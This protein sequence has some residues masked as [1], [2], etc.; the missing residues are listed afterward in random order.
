MSKVLEF[1]QFATLFGKSH[2]PPLISC[3]A[4]YVAQSMSARFRI[5]LLLVQKE[6]SPQLKTK[7]I[8]HSVEIDWCSLWI[9]AQKKASEGSG[10]T[11]TVTTTYWCIPYSISFDEQIDYFGMLGRNR[12]LHADGG[13]DKQKGKTG[14]DQAMS[15]SITEQRSL[16]SVP[17]T[18]HDERKRRR[19]GGR[20]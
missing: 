15:S 16:S 13:R 17:Q 19:D 7:P 20:V 11:F 8:T 12:S 4:L 5:T 3:G 14:E 6:F 18:G 9:Q 1:Q 2:Y 10:E